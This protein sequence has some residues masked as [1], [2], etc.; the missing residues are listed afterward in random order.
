MSLN[1]EGYPAPSENWDSGD[2][3]TDLVSYIDG[4]KRNEF[5]TEFKDNTSKIFSDSN[6]EKLRALYGNNYVEALDDMLHR[7][8]TGT[9]RKFGA[10]KIE[11][12]FMDWTNNSVGAIMFFNAR[13][14]VLQ[15]LSAVNF[16]NFSDN[17]PINAG[18]AFANQPQ[19]WKDFS[20]LFN[21]DFLKQRR[22][23]LQTDVNADEIANASKSSSNKAKAALSAILKL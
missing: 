18:L 9:N 20:A 21:S 17:N 2:I 8:K 23:G 1:P 10:S 13:S 16:I 12:Q 14:A 6:K 19:Y 11:R 4:V 15:T 5:L 7:M 22:S 3:T